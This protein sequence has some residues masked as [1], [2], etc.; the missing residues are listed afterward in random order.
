MAAK[1]TEE[2]KSSA[3]QN[4]AKPAK[5]RKQPPK[6][7]GY[8]KLKSP[9]DKR[10]KGHQFSAKQIVARKDK[11]SDTYTK[12]GKRLTVREEKFINAYLNNNTAAKSAI[13]AG[14]KCGEDEEFARQIGNQVLSKPYIKAEI[15]ARMEQAKASGIADRQE[16][17]QFFS[18]MMRGKILDQFDMPTTNADKI[19]AAQELAKRSI[20]FEDRLKE[21]AQATVPE[22]KISLDWGGAHG[23]K[24]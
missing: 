22:I 17:L 11:L 18:D 3:K 7:K 2:K 21:K 14:Y 1:K 8:G 23:K 16:I 4:T 6:G 10:L 24:E 15:Q 20:D 19:K 5:T 13:E 9:N 12:E